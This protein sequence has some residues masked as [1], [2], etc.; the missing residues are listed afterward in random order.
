MKPTGALKFM[1]DTC[2]GLLGVLWF[3]NLPP[4]A[5]EKHRNYSDFWVHWSCRD[6][7]KEH[8]NYYSILGLYGNYPP[9]GCLA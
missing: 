5:T 2:F 7:G 3:V 6:N 9:E 1:N 8:G 4:Q